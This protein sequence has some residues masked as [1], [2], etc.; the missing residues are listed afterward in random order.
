M[1][2]LNHL[3]VM[4]LIALLSLAWRVAATAATSPEY[5]GPGAVYFAN[6]IA[7]LFIAAITIITL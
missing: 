1:C 2:P 5:A 3:S 6:P 4:K 7:A